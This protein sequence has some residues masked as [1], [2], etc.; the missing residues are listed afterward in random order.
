MHMWFIARGR[1]QVMTRRAYNPMVRTE[2]A[3]PQRRGQTD[4]PTPRG[5]ALPCRRSERGS[6]CVASTLSAPSSRLGPG[7]FCR[8]ELRAQPAPHPAALL[9]AE[10]P[11]QRSVR[12]TASECACARVSTRACARACT[13][14]YRQQVST[15]RSCV[16]AH[17]CVCLRARRCVSSSRYPVFFTYT[18][19]LRICG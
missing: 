15:T 7:S 17:T 1:S 18:P 4:D 13:C 8:S 12:G 6:G 3:G 14:P 11:G 5:P 10:Q 19:D 16:C 9:L 2:G